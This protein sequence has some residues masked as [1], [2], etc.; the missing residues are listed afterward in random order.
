MDLAF[1]ADDESARVA[2]LPVEGGPGCLDVGLGYGE[3][4]LVV[5]GG[6]RLA[7]D[8]EAAE[9]ADFVDRSIRLRRRAVE[10]LDHEPLKVL[11][12]LDTLGVPVAVDRHGESVAAGV[13]DPFENGFELTGALGRS[14]GSS[15]CCLVGAA[16]P[17]LIVGLTPLQFISS[18]RT[19]PGKTKWIATGKKEQI[20]NPG[21]GHTEFLRFDLKTSPAK[22]NSKEK[23]HAHPHR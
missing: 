21:A 22:E 10:A 11:P 15:E 8:R 13:D 3:T 4:D 14:I 16:E 18:G 23:P 2:A 12:G 7:G 20:I 5:D 9:R 6:D 17:V 1:E 19:E